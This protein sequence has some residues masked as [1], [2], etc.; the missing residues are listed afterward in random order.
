[1]GFRCWAMALVGRGEA[2]AGWPRE[3]LGLRV[4][5]ACAAWAYMREWER[6]KPI[7]VGQGERRNR[8][9]WIGLWAR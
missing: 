5:R 7:G 3:E 2:G 9:K 1:M 8:A 6:R 4:E